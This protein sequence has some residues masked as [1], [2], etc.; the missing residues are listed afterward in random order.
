MFCW[1]N[2]IKRSTPQL[3]RLLFKPSFPQ[4]IYHYQ[5][6]Y[7]F[8][9]TQ[10]PKTNKIFDSLRNISLLKDD[11][12]L[13]VSDYEKILTE[14]R[15]SKSLSSLP[16]EEASMAVRLLYKLATASQKEQDLQKSLKYYA[17]ALALSEK[18]G[19]VDTAEL[20]C[21]NNSLGSVYL[22]QDDLEEAQKY[23]DKASQIF[24]KQQTNSEM[25]SQ[26]VQNTF[27]RGMLFDRKEQFDKALELYEQALKLAN[28][29]SKNDAAPS[30]VT[31][32]DN[33]GYI[34]EKKGNLQKAVEHWKQGLETAVGNYGK[35]SMEAKIFYE[36]LAWA[37]FDMNNLKEAI[38]YAENAL[39]ISIKHHGAESSGIT[40]CLFLLGDIY[41]KQGDLKKALEQYEKCSKIFE[42]DPQQT[43]DQ[44]AHNYM[45]IARNYLA[46]SD[47]KKA[48]EAF[49]KAVQTLSGGNEQQSIKLAEYYYSWGD[50]LINNIL[51]VNEAKE[52]FSKALEILKK[53]GS[54]DKSRLS[55]IYSH[56]GEIE[57][58][59]DKYDEA[60]KLFQECINF[61]K[62]DKEKQQSLEEVYSFIGDIYSKKNNYAESATY[63]KK[64]ID[65]C[66][67]REKEHPD[68]DFHYRNLGETYEK[69]GELEKARDIYQKVLDF[70][71]K[72]YGKE[73]ETTQRNLQLVVD[74]LGK[75]NKS[76]EAEELKKKYT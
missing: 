30:F 34:Y 74:V 62:D 8:C 50:Q 36:N 46:Q 59:D 54:K 6:F 42:K 1:S 38:E 9:S 24:Q 4:P 55:D 67:G 72:K 23:L 12:N 65:I 7:T 2:L 73:D 33:I 25:K 56:L 58:Y 70:A 48:S 35:D 61:A 43:I 21:I 32:Y 60:L 13:K 63:H 28:E 71:E 52:A 75:L 76:K 40:S 31:I 66:C 3:K 15:S 27:M 39:K 37:Y 53:Y 11:P 57:Y 16:K 47:Q 14:L 49:A 10:D 22:R 20:G 18:V 69:A 44:R 19:I 26:V 29:L 64:A 5:S 51:T 45:L 41:S 17:E 68:L